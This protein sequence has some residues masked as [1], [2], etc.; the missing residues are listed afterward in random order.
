MR[1]GNPTGLALFRRHYSHRRTRGDTSLFVGPGEKLVLIT[2]CARAMFVWR[3]FLNDDG[4]TGINC[5]VFR[6]EGAG[7]GQSSDLIRAADAIADRK[8]PGQRHY[9]YVDPRKV[10]SANPGWCFICAGYRRCGV[11]KKR[12]LL[13]LERL[14]P[15]PFS[16]VEYPCP[17]VQGF[18]QG[19]S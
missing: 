16:V 17:A 15:E 11:T 2:P 8:W 14:P 4:Q 3:N 6:N 19:E 18:L 7:E 12:R 13:I 1:D 9:T 5:A 10:R